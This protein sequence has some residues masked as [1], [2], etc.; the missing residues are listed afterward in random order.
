M[1]SVPA[2]KKKIT[3]A[4]IDPKN[5]PRGK[6]ILESMRKICLDLPDTTEGTQFGQA[7]WLAGK[8]AFA[9]SHCYDGL[10]Q[11]G[12]WVGIHAQQAMTNDPRFTIPPYMGHNGWI[13]LDITKKHNESELRQLALES[14][15]HFA[16]K[17]MLA[18]LED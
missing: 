14:Y 2:P 15:R 3:A 5:T 17:R 16:S 13:S 7:V 12:F 10:W 18:K 8:K 11:A 4:D 1:P 6:K 9:R